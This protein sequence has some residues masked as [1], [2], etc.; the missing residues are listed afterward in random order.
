MYAV[1]MSRQFLNGYSVLQKMYTTLYGGL[2]SWERLLPNDR[3]RVVAK[4]FSAAAEGNFTV[5]CV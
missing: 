2:F 4:L 5:D 1:A 3:F